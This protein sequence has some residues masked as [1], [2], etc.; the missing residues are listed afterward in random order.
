MPEASHRAWWE[1]LQGAL[2]KVRPS[3]VAGCI[4]EIIELFGHEWFDSAGVGHVLYLY[5]Y[6][7]LMPLAS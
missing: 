1:L 3:V 5:G 2:V 6:K 4:T 7:G